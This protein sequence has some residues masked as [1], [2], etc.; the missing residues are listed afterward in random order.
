MFSFSG[1]NLATVKRL[2]DEYHIYLIGNGR[3]SLAGLNATNVPIF[4]SALR[5]ILGVNDNF[6]NVLGIE[7]TASTED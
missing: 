5:N 2:K 1:I 4:V 7:G 6:Y 3:I